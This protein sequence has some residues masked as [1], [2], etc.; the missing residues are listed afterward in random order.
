MAGADRIVISKVDEAE[1]V[2]PLVRTLRERELSVSLLGLGQRVPEDLVE[3]E[4]EMIAA[5]LLG[6]VPVVHA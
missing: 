5:C 6:Q 4:S 3:G 2:M 1:T